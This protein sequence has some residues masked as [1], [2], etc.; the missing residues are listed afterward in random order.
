M[1]PDWTSA[2]FL[3]GNVFVSEPGLSVSPRSDL[4]SQDG[5]VVS[6]AAV[7]VHINVH[8]P[9]ARHFKRIWSAAEIWFY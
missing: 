7:F 3:T 8:V 5:P 6:Q 4:I 9:G 1:E 2:A